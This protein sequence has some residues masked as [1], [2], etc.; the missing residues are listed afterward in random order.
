MYKQKSYKCYDKL[1]VSISLVSFIVAD[2]YLFPFLRR[3]SWISELLV[4]SDIIHNRAG[5]ILDLE[6]MGIAVGILSLSCVQAKL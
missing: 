6:N 2:L 1:A 5:G 3:P 4:T